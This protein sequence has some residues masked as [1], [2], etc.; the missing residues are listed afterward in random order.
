MP[1]ALGARNGLVVMPEGIYSKDLASL[2]T[3]VNKVAEEQGD[4]RATQDANGRLT[5]SRM[6]DPD[7]SGSLTSWTVGDI[8]S[9]LTVKKPFGATYDVFNQE[10]S[11]ELEDFAGNL[12]GSENLPNQFLTPYDLFTGRKDISFVDGLKSGLSAGAGSGSNSASQAP[13]T[14]GVPVGVPSQLPPPV[15]NIR[16]YTRAEWG[17]TVPYS[18]EVQLPYNEVIVHTAA[19]AESKAS[20]TVEQALKEVL[21][22]HNFHIR[23]NGWSQIG[24]NFVICGNG[25]IAEARGWG[26]HGAHTQ[27]GRNKQMGV[28]FFGHGDQQPATPQQWASMQGL[29]IE[30]VKSGKLIPGYVVTGHR[31]YAAKSCPGNLIYPL[32]KQLEGLG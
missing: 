31:N 27:K 16:I 24:Y 9:G 25:L 7:P 11:K 14:T 12:G 21:A 2:D 17:C 28:C 22:V 29:L 26:R 32:I 10:L 5:T 8:L 23:A 30:A 4:T 18:K 13:S 15:T 3:L 19:G 20:N 1:Y 6:V